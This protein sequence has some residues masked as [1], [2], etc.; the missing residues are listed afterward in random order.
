MAFLED[1]LEVTTRTDQGVTIIDL[2][3]D[4]TT[5]ADAKITDAYR[6]A[7]AEG[8][9]KI[10]LNFRRS[11]YINSAGI[12]ILI[13]IVTEVNRAGQKLAMS[14]LNDH[15]QKIFRMVGLSQYAHIYD[16]EHLA[17]VALNAA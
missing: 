1:G 16:D 17:V 7:T 11:D 15:F 13:R 3:G 12:A 6:T 4:V 14:G 8:A 2:K 5:F 9:R 10:V